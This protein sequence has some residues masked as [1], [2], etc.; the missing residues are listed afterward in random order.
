MQISTF[1]LFC[2]VELILLLSS[3]D[4]IKFKWKNNRL[5]VFLYFSNIKK[6]LVYLKIN[7]RISNYYYY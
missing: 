1:S 2:G 6:K 5:N 7:E 3:N 4:S